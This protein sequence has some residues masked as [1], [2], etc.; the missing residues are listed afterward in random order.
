MTI[1]TSEHKNITFTVLERAVLYA[2]VSGDDTRKEGRNLAGQLEMGRS[3]AH[4]K[5]YNIVAELSEDD[6]GASGAD[7][8]LPQLNR[9]REMAHAKEFDVLIVREIDR[10]SRNLAKQLI[11][12]EELHK[13]GVRVEYIL[14]SYD[15]TPEGRL[16][17]HIRATVAEYERE[18]IKERMRRG[19][20]LKVKAGNIL[21]AARA[22]YGYKPNEDGNSFVVNDAEAETVRYIFS[23]F[24][25]G[26]TVEAIRRKLTELGIPTPS[27]VRKFHGVDKLVSFGQWNRA[28]IHKILTSETYI[29][30]WYYGKAKNKKFRKA[31]GSTGYR[32][33][34]N[35]KN[36]WIK[37]DVPPIISQD[38]FVFVQTKLTEN[39][40]RR[41]KPAK[42]KW[43]LSKRVTCNECEYKMGVEA[44]RRKGEIKYAYYVCPASRRKDVPRHCTQKPFNQSKVDEVVWGWIVETMSDEK[45][46]EHA[47]NSNAAKR[48]KERQ[49]I[50]RQFDA[51]NAKMTELNTD[52]TNTLATLKTLRPGSR[53]Y[54]AVLEDMDRLEDALN[55]LEIQRKRLEQQLEQK[56]GAE[57]QERIF[58]IS[59]KVR[60]GFALAK[61]NFDLRK[62]VIETLDVTVRLQRIDG[63]AY[64][65][66]TCF[67]GDPE[68]PI[69][70][71][72]YR[73]HFYPP[74]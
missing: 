40:E 25:Q 47:L 69:L 13:A 39:A 34:K 12:E 11:I 20:Q 74:R 43:L 37:V 28:T 60:E 57:Q 35:S 24:L 44:T 10:L 46:L 33:I 49:P 3:Y 19:K 16:Q 51:T 48:D 64:A 31:D 71:T 15:D 29:G 61:E 14:A 2:R 54:A 4:E 1:Q 26:N 41:G 65:F 36:Q 42:G 59:A 63:V 17:K 32:A 6:K 22:P 9:V 27:D 67:I 58:A 70:S 23:L 66:V 45:R 50:Q 52:L 7:I 5:G 8:D 18:K 30:T 73:P 38:V 53:A 21:N 68:L 56:L 55:K 62:E 72:K